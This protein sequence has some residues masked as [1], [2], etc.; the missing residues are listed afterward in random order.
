[1]TFPAQIKALRRSLRL[2]QRELGEVLDVSGQTVNNWERGRAVPW[3][4]T[5]EKAV[6]HLERRLELQQP[7]RERARVGDRI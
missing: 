3:P 5:R 6:A 2:T 4:A 7:R 1:M